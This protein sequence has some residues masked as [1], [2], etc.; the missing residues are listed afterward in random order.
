MATLNPKVQAW[1]DKWDKEF[2]DLQTKHRAAEQADWE[3]NKSTYEAQGYHREEDPNNY[4][5]SKWSYKGN[6]SGT[7]TGTGTG[8]GTGTGTGT[9]TKTGIGTGTGTGTDIKVEDYSDLASS[10]QNTINNIPQGRMYDPYMGLW[11][12]GN[13]PLATPGLKMEPET[14]ADVEEDSNN[15]PVVFKYKFKTVDAEGNRLGGTQYA[16]DP[17][18]YNVINVAGNPD[19][20]DEYGNT[21]AK[22]NNSDKYALLRL[23]NKYSG[24]LKV[25]TLRNGKYEQRNVSVSYP[26]GYTDT[27]NRNQFVTFDKQGGTMNKVNY[28]KQG[29]SIKEQLRPLVLGVLSKN[30]ESTQKLQQIVKQN[31]QIMKV[32][33]EIAAEEQAKAQS[34]ATMH[35]WGSK[36]EYIRSLKFGKGGKS[37]PVCDQQKVEM[38]KCG[39][40]KAKKHQEGGEFYFNETNPMRMSN[41]R[42]VVG[43]VNRETFKNPTN[44]GISQTVYNQSGRPVVQ[45]DKT[46]NGG[47]REIYYNVPKSIKRKG[48]IGSRYEMGND[49]VYVSGTPE[50][51]QNS[52]NMSTSAKMNQA[53]RFAY[54]M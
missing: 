47:E 53:N 44:I 12:K 7:G 14:Y 24:P 34:Q 50:M 27:V 39:G 54:G 35:K 3:A 33:E 31:P 42:N 36:L 18:K 5:G 48:F 21:W 43:I 8:A 45:K 1:K 46:S 9:K 13:N 17:S 11:N 10:I 29:G 25:G 51:F 16:A 37:C 2:S 32:V 40:K 26:N 20:T 28:F 41:G 4:W 52:P 23:G 38:K 49:T 19:I 22:V 15:L 6:T 30:P